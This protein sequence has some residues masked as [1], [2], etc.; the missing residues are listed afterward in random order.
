[1]VYGFRWSRLGKL[2]QT[3]LSH[4]EHG[5][6]ELVVALDWEQGGTILRKQPLAFDSL[7]ERRN[8]CTYMA[9][10]CADFAVNERLPQV[11]TR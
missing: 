6:G 1:M 9:S 4:H 5:Q 8:A 3:N 11:F 7:N 2:W 10:V